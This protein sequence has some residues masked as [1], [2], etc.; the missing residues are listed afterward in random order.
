MTTT[1]GMAQDSMANRESL[2]A[3]RPPAHRG[4]ARRAKILALPLALAALAGCSTIDRVSNAITGGPSLQPGQAGYV[5]GFLGN[6]AAEEPRAALVARDVLSAGG[7]AADAAAAAGFALTVTLPSRAGLGGG[8]ACLGY[9]PRRNEI[10]AF[11][12]QPGAREGVPRGADRPA[13]IPMMARGLFALHARQGRLPFERTIAPAEGMARFGTPV[14]R[15]LSTDLAA[16]AGPLLADP[17]SRAVFAPGGNPVAEGAALT[18]TELAT[19]L[20]GIRTAGVGD[21]H[22]GGLARRVEEGSAAAGGFLTVAEMR[23]AVPQAVPAA[24]ERVG[25]DVLGTLP[26][27]VDGGATLAAFRAAASGGSPSVVA[28]NFGASTSVV[29][30]DREGGAVACAFTMNNLFGTGRMVPGMGFL[31]APAPGMGGVQAPPLGAV[32]LANLNVKT[33]RYVGAGSGQGAAPAAAGGPAGLHLGR[34]VP[35]GQ[36]IASGAPEPGRGVAV[37]CQGSVRASNCGAVADARGFGVSTG[38]D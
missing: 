4:A 23:S 13:A 27:S 22:Q 11:L 7:S 5:Q 16:V 12:F 15:A 18:Q 3:P 14:S 6:V 10:E 37:S 17:V 30:Q 33:M 26:A 20:S 32:L 9:D 21:F 8:G 24:Q 36:A 34:R 29:V 28:G 1:A 25:S 2:I 35:L 31:L 38:N 19:T